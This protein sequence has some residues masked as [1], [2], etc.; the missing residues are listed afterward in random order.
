MLR[1]MAFRDRFNT[2]SARNRLV[3]ERERLVAAERRASAH[4]D[5]LRAIMDDMSNELAQRS[6]DPV[7]TAALIVRAGEKARGRV[8]TPLPPKG[9]TARAIVL[10]GMRARGEKDVP[11]E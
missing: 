9:S 4:V 6:I 8:P 5:D 2:L 3:A 10:A 11:N 1:A 7:R